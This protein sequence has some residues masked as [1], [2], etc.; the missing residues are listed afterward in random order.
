[1]KDYL[2]QASFAFRSFTVIT[3]NRNYGPAENVNCLLS[4]EIWDRYD[5]VI[6]SE[7]DNIFANTFLQ[8]VDY[9]LARFENDSR[10][11][12]VGGFA[13]PAK[14]KNDGNEEIVLLN[15]NANT[16]GFG[17]WRDRYMQMSALCATDYYHSI[18]ADKERTRRILTGS[19]NDCG[20]MA[21]YVMTGNKALND[22]FMSV[23]ARDNGK[24]C[25]YPKISKTK[26]YGSDGSGL[27]S[28]SVDKFGMNSVVMDKRGS[29]SEEIFDS[30]PQFYEKETFEAINDVYRINIYKKL[31]IRFVYVTH[32]FWKK[33]PSAGIALRSLYK[34][35]SRRF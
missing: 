20:A 27:N 15:S 21:W 16:W 23:F 34:R 2:A 24:Y 17:I 4:S 14:W 22:T 10:F 7:D 18:L 11:L 32:D 33:H 12:L 26:N 9:G 3:R 5:R 13:I 31:F 19:M 25:V 35:M 30:I 29:I 6:L 28:G 8:F 1:M